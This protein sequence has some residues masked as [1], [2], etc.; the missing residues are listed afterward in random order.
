VVA[1]IGV[2]RAP[3]FID[4]SPDGKRAYVANS[5]SAN[6]SVIDLEQRKVLNYISTGNGS[7]L[8]RVTPDGKLA[9]VALRDEDAIAVVDVEKLAVRSKVKICAKP[10]EMA[11]VPDSSKVFVACSESKQVGVVELKSDKDDKS[12]DKLLTLLD[13]GKTPIHLVAKPDGGEVFVCN[14]DGSSVSALTTNS[15]EVSN[16]FPIGDRPARALVAP[17][18]SLLYVANFG[19]D[20]VAV[21]NIDTGRWISSVTVGNHP[22]GLVFSPNQLHLLVVN[23]GSGDMTVLSLIGE[24]SKGRPRREAPSLETMIPLGKDPRAIVVKAFVSQR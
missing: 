6:L 22:E 13:V 18:N 2:H 16:T 8:A 4:V 14:Y 3:F 21:Y 15:N 23:T 9:I 1:T 10:V 7:N 12:A 19:S 5:G 24:N 20:S 11:I 17:D